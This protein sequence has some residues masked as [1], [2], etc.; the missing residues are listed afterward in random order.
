M[1]RVVAIRNGTYAGECFTD[2]DEE[3][4]VR[5]ATVSYSLT[6]RVPDDDH[7]DIH[8]E[9]PLPDWV[10]LAGLVDARAL[11]RLPETIGHPDAS[12]AGG[13]F[14]EVAAEEGVKR[15]DFDLGADL[16][17][18]APLLGKLRALRSLQREQHG[19]S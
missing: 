19:R 10:E 14:V 16:P 12:D 8:V 11:E 1:S 6:S 3:I 9:S 7:P 17:E 15:V 4:V 5:E 18:L 2:C 13:E